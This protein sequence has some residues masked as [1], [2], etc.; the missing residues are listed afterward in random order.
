MIRRLLAATALATGLVA[1]AAGPASADPVPTKVNTNN[2]NIACVYNL[3]PL[4][5][6][7][8]IGV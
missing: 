5:I 7:L 1:L 2:G 3:K 6:G 8:C 4:D